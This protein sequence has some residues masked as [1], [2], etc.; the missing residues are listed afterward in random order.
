MSGATCFPFRILLSGPI[1]ADAL[2]VRWTRPP[3]L[4]LA[5][6]QTVDRM[7][8]RELAR[9]TDS[10]L[11]DGTV[12]ALQDWTRE[13]PTVRL[14]LCPIPYRVVWYTYIAAQDPRLPLPGVIPRALGVSAVVEWEGFLLLM[15]RSRWVAEFPGRLDVF[16]G[17]IERDVRGRWLSPLESVKREV[18]E[19]L[20]LEPSTISVLS[21]LGLLRVAG[22]QKPELVF[23]ARLRGVRREDWLRR[24]TDEVEETVLV[25]ADRAQE[26]LLQNASELTPSGWGSLQLWLELRSP[27]QE[28]GE[29]SDGR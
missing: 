1:D 9:R 28:L 15:R 21:V 11:F 27:P 20:G 14:V 5:W 26:F 17:H 7:W 4:P 6:L 3:S 16:G 29:G 12:A 22:T 25:P 19:E 23:S 10:S 18:S 2:R 8:Q 24:A 13:G